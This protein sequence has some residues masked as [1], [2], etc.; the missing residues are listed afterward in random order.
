MPIKKFENG[1]IDKSLNILHPL[2]KRVNELVDSVNTG[3]GGGSGDGS[4][5]I[6]T[7]GTNVT[8]TGTGTTIDPY[9]VNSSGG[10]GG[11][12]VDSVNGE[13]GV[14]VLDTGDIAEVTDKKYV[15][16]AH[17]V[18]LGNTSGTNSGDNAT[19]TTSDTYAD[20][21]V[22][23]TTTVNGHALSS[24]VTVTASDVGLGNVDNT[25][26][27]TKNS[28]TVT[29]TNKTLTSPVI[30]SPTG[31][32]K[33]DVGLGN[34]DNTSDTNKP[35]STAQQTAL[36]L[37]ANLVSPTFTGTV[38]LPSTTS[39]G[40]VSSTELGYV[41]GVTS[42]IQTQL[43]AKAGFGFGASSVSGSVSLDLTSFASGTILTVTGDITTFAVSNGVVGRTYY[44]YLVQDATGSRTITGFDSKFKFQGSV[45]PYL[46]STALYRT[47]YQIIIYSSAL[48]D[49]IPIYDL[50]Q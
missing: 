30:N 39:I 21:K 43:D 12:D 42:A 24:N 20:T 7:S 26:D 40:T 27:A 15:T 28:A 44:I 6:I 33:G 10:G 49:L 31:I 17:L 38:V 18:I 47:L 36:D 9:V 11:G 35:V 46:N 4:E 23:Q 22:P 1:E 19:N 5:T 45:T 50:G 48:Y 37:K 32:V 3:G 29:L 13:T 25:S 16:D 8:V 14:V 34:V 2:L 41:D